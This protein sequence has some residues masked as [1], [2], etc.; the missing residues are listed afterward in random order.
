MQASPLEP[1]PPARH[2]S[3]LGSLRGCDFPLLTAGEVNAAVQHL[4][5]DSGGGVG[6]DSILQIFAGSGDVVSV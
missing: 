2:I 4:E 5:D 1:A 3:V 6:L